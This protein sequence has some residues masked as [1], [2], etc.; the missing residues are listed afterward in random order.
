MVVGGAASLWIARTV[1]EGGGVAPRDGLWAITA[2]P[3]LASAGISAAMALWVKLRVV[4][5]RP[6][7]RGDEPAHR[8]I[9]LRLR[10]TLSL[11]EL[12]NALFITSALYTCWICFAYLLPVLL[13]DRQMVSE[14]GAFQSILKGYY[15]FYLAMGTSRF[16]GPYLSARFHL[17]S[18]QISRFR[19]WGV[20]NCGALAVGGIAILLRRQGADGSSGEL[21]TLLV[22]LALVVFWAAKIAEEAFKPVRTTYLNYLVGRQR[23]PRV[24]AVDGNAVRRGHRAG[25]DRRARHRAALPALPR[26]GP[27]LDPAAVRDP[28]RALRGADGPAIAPGPARSNPGSVTSALQNRLDILHSRWRDATTRHD[29]LLEEHVNE[30]S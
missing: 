22:P 24:R 1:V 20:L 3:W 25:R 23:R 5:R 9:W 18:D 12:R 2:L 4:E 7:A 27:V 30:L 10:R 17:G 21:N 14:A 28:R 16:I 6:P 29:L 8:R 26:R 19:W 15:W 11:R 13:T